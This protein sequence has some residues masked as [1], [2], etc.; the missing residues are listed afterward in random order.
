MLLLLGTSRTDS[1]CQGENCPG[2]ICPGDIICPY[3]EY[4]N[5]YLHDI[6]QTLKARSRQGQCKVKAR[7][8]QARGNIKAR[9]GQGQGKVKRFWQ[10][11][12]KVE[13]RSRG[14]DKA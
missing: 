14:K 2:N 12:R 6:D 8:M 9:L 1:I 10:G 13:E 4:H 11:K 7:S 5:S 3:Q